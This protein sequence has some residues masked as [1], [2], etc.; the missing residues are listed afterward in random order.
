[1][2]PWLQTG[3]SEDLVFR[4]KV[5]AAPCSS[6]MHARSN[7]VAARYQDQAHRQSNTVPAPP[8]TT[9][10][11]NTSQ[12]EWHICTM[13]IVFH[14]VVQTSLNTCA[15]VSRCAATESEATNPK[16]VSAVDAAGGA[17]PDEDAP[18]PAEHGSGFYGEEGHGDRMWLVPQESIASPTASN[19]ERRQWPCMQWQIVRTCGLCNM[20]LTALVLHV[21]KPTVNQMYPRIS[22]SRLAA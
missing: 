16:L 9:G 19:A 1:M 6:F 15:Q 5:S 17:A 22:D 7:T 14:Y 18:S 21:I 13:L 20:L 12:E 3:A 8:V 4:G 10:D 2:K 11:I